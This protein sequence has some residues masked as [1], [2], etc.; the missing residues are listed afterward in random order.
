VR[1]SQRVR[2]AR[3]GRRLT[4]GP[5]EIRE[6]A[7]GIP[8]ALLTERLRQLERYGIVTRSP[9]PAGRGFVYELTEAGR[10]LQAVCDALGAWGAR[11]LEL[12]PAHLDAAMVLWS[13]CRCMPGD[14]IPEPR[15]VVRFDVTDNTPGRLWVLAQ[16]PRPEVCVKPPGFDEDLVVRTDSASLA[17]WQLGWV[18]LGTAQRHGLMHVKGPVHLQRELAG[19]AGRHQFADIA[20]AR[21]A[22]VAAPS[23]VPA[24]A[25]PRSND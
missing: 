25:Y 18:S 7:P 16:R 11:W 24:P 10:G 21:G 8:R 14:E 6:G 22:G 13:M 12:A 17:K 5:G 4:P 1:R 20:P 2:G 9:N 19:W 15:M 3:A 23:K